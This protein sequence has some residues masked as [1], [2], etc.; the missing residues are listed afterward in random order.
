MNVNLCAAHGIPEVTSLTFISENVPVFLLLVSWDVHPH[1]NA[2][3]LHFNLQFILV[4][5]K[6]G[7]DGWSLGSID[8][9]EL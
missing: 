6:I 4:L 1:R 8:T 2:L 3:L 9:V 5:T 7:H